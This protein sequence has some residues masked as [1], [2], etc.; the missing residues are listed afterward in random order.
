[1][2]ELLILLIFIF[3]KYSRLVIPSLFILFFISTAIE[4]FLI[5]FFLFFNINLY[6]REAIFFCF[7]VKSKFL[8]D[9]ASP[10][11][12]L[13]VLHPTTFIFLNF[14]L[15]KFSKNVPSLQAISNILSFFLN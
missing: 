6:T 13:I 8:D 7:L 2:D 5:N 3:L 15:I 1:M 10:F 9:I 4:D 14:F 12:S 11:F